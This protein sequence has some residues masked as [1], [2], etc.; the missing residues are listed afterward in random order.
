MA[1]VHSTDTLLERLATPKPGP[2][3][4]R[5]PGL[6]ARKTAALIAEMKAKAK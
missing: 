2:L 4:S 3:T 5:L 1:G 6:F